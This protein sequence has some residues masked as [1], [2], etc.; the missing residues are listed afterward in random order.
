MSSLTVSRKSVMGRDCLPFDVLVEI[1][2]C[3][4]LQGSYSFS[5]CFTAA[6]D[7]VYYVFSHREVLDFESVWTIERV[8]N[9]QL[10]HAHTRAC[11]ISSVGRCFGAGELAWRTC[12]MYACAKRIFAGFSPHLLG[13]SGGMLP[14]KFFEI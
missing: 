11:C 8:R 6:Y 13:G 7:V 2:K 3:L 10:L 12:E 9:L 5:K 4:N 1:A 14:R